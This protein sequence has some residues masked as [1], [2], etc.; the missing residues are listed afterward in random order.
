M[1]FLFP[2]RFT[3]L[4]LN[5]TSSFIIWLAMTN[6]FLFLIGC[7]LFVVSVVPFAKYLFAVLERTASGYADAPTLSYELIRPMEEWRP[8]LLILT[9]GFLVSFSIWLLQNNQVFLTLIL[10]VFFL[11]AMPAFIGLL[12]VNNGL[13]RSLNPQ[14]LLRFMQRVG[15]TYWILLGILATGC[16]FLYL[17]YTSGAGLYIAIAVNLYCLVLVFHWLGKIIYVKREKLG[18]TPDKS[19]ERQA[20]QINHEIVLQRKKHMDRVFSRRRQAVALPILLAC[21]EEEE[22]KLDAH[23]W[24]HADLM[25]WDNKRLGIR[26]AEF[27]IK[28]L[29]EA[30]NHVIADLVLQEC[31][32]IYPE[33]TVAVGKEPGEK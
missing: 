21:I 6:I 29:R 7:P 22:N 23:A 11:G 1:I 15:I 28:A 19:P 4:L 27:Y 3:P 25:Q 33:F 12:G 30:G 9:L 31:R 20:E 18:Y 32:E 16:V 8:Y 24:Y 13:F 17:L 14:I 10:L 26:H 5:L 2:L